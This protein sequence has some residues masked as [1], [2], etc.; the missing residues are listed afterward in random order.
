MFTVLLR[1]GCPILRGPS[2]RYLQFMGLEFRVGASFFETLIVVAK[3]GSVFLSRFRVAVQAK[4]LH[5]CDFGLRA[6]TFNH[7]NLNPDPE[8]TR[9]PKPYALKPHPELKT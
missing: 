3:L 5:P 7:R 2:G 4:A 6:R 1:T 8:R 9:H